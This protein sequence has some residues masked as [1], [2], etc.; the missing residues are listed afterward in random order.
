MDVCEADVRVGGAYRYV[1]RR[2]DEL[3]GFSGT[4][5]ELNPPT[6]LV[7][8]QIF[9]PFPDAAV[10]VRITLTPMGTETLLVSHE[11]YP[12][13]EAREMA[14]SAGME[15]GMRETMEQLSVLLQELT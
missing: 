4:Y 1:M 6:G 3:I 10:T 11:E 8:T 13:P 15:H 5:L 14:I 12:S 9:D 7:Y 2:G